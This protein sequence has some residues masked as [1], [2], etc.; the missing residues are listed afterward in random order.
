MSQFPGDKLDQKVPGTTKWNIR[1][2]P[3]AWM[4]WAAAELERIMVSRELMSRETGAG[5]LRLKPKRSERATGPNGASD[6]NVS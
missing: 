1:E 3:G 6:L 5:Q 2:P 4:A